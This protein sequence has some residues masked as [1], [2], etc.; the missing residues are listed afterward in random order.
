MNKWITVADV[1]DG[2]LQED[3]LC[4][5]GNATDSFTATTDAACN[6]L[7]TDDPLYANNHS[8][9]CGG[10]GVVTIYQST[11]TYYYLMFICIKSSHAY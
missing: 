4:L 6:N 5:C 2:A 7:C 10:S 3:G 1:C 9:T 8:Y 11:Y